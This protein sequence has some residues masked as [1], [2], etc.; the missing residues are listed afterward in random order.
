[1]SYATV[2]Q[3]QARVPYYTISDASKVTAAMVQGY[4]DQVS[5]E[6]DS[7]VVGHGVSVPVTAPSYWLSSLSETVIIGATARLL[8]AAYPPMGSDVANPNADREWL[9]YEK[10]IA[11]LVTGD[12][13][14]P[15]VITSENDEDY[16]GLFDIIEQPIDA[17]SERERLLNQALRGDV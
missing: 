6:V 1:M 5:A 8:K 9:T 2:A 17:F 4:I 14:P 16:E 11:A 12:G 15:G 10:R 3:V 13:I 7:A